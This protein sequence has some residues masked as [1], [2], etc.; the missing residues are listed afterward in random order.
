MSR[1]LDTLAE[2]YGDVHRQWNASATYCE[3][4]GIDNR[5][6][7]GFCGLVTITPISLLPNRRFDLRDND[8]G[9]DLGVVIEAMD[10]SGEQAIDLVAWPAENP[11]DVRTLCG[12]APILGLWAALN[13]ATYIFDHPLEIHRTPLDWLRAD[14]TGAAIIIPKIAGRFLIDLPGPFGGQDAGHVRSLR[15]MVEAPGKRV[16]FLMPSPVRRAA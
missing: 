2:L 11:R 4:H 7:H 9:V 1:R 14:C 6:C 8:A 12:L 10:G 16:E 13:P 3:R 5:A 15:K